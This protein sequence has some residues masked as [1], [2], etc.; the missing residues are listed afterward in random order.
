MPSTVPSTAPWIR[1]RPVQWQ[2]G[3]RGFETPGSRACL[4]VHS[5]TRQRRKTILHAWT[6]LLWGYLDRWARGWGH[7]DL[8]LGVPVRSSRWQHPPSTAGRV[9]PCG[10]GTVDS[11]STL[12]GP[13]R[14]TPLAPKR[15]D[16]RTIGQPHC[17]LA[18]HRYPLRLVCPWPGY[19]GVGTTKR[20]LSE[21]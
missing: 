11:N 21:A 2:P 13:P 4:L 18:I 15:I 8:N 5:A 1:H 10:Q 9:C 16:F 6:Y 20:W 19:H 14:W 12:D 3:A 7:D 17:N